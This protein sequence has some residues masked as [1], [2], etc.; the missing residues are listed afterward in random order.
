MF[1][2]YNEILVKDVLDKKFIILNENDSLN[3]AI[4][5]ML[6]KNIQEVFIKDKRK[7]IQGVITLS[8]ISLIYQNISD[9]IILN[10]F[11]VKK[12][13]Y[14]SKNETLS[15]CRSIMIKN[16]IGRLPVI[17]NDKIIGVIRAEEIRDYF[18]MNLEKMGQTLH[19]IVNNIHEA[20]CLIDT[21]G[22]VMIWNKN[23]EDLYDIAKE[24]IIGKNIKDFFP[25]SINS[26]VLETRKEMTNTYH[27]PK[28]NYRV[29]VNAL[30]IFIK[31]E[32]E[33]VLTTDRNITE[34]TSLS[35]EL[36][37]ANNTLKFLES[38]YK[39]LKSDD[40]GNVI[41]RSPK[42]IEKIKIAKQVAKTH[43]SV[44]VSGESGTGKE[45]FA[46]NIHDYSGV[47]GLFIP[48]NC[49]AIPNELFESEFFGYDEGAFTGAS[50][51]GKMGFFELANNGTLFL[52]EIG[53]LPLFMQ[54][55]L[56]RVL[57]DNKFSRV[58]GEKLINT[59]VRIISAT[60]KSL[61]DMVDKGNFREDLFYRLNV[62]EIELPPLRERK[63][64][65]VLLIHYFLKELA[66]KNNKKIPKISSNVLEILKKYNWKGNIRELKNTVEYL[67]VLS[68]N[69]VI[70]ENMLPH[71]ILD[72]VGDYKK[73]IKD[74]IIKS[75]DLNKSIEELEKKLINEA[76]NESQGNKAKASKLLKIPRSTLHYKIN[77]YGI[78]R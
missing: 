47:S 72:E 41:G 46:K 44:L 65:V 23:A 37:K 52:D 22:K 29:V 62:I 10:K 26:K 50:K 57:Q 49:S 67:L 77:N 15:K 30:P 39:R 18:Y 55:K 63:N 11:L 9:N 27:T 3:E 28:K 58:G 21:K 32:F 36:K 25:D 8:D 38:E 56:L 78:E 68:A 42:I 43:I 61:V 53:E 19:H 2:D 54:A 14:V 20:L 7:K 33:G 69:D 48:V 70:Y 1:F 35:D 34:V 71:H 64:D 66:E 12:F 17:E 16:K 76:L 59:N 13:I 5:S 73:N 24:E 75:F 74:D 60:N 40:F 4:E 31:G 6:K 51:K 45:V